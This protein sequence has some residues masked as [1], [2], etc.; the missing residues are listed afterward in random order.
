MPSGD[1][2]IDE[3]ELQQMCISLGHELSTE[4][5]QRV[6]MALDTSGDGLV[7]FEEFLEL[8]NSTTLR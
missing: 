4:D 2:F 8:M 7:D 1:D 6:M 3:E 5:L